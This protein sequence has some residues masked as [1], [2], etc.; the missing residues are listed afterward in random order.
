MDLELCLGTWKKNMPE[1]G[2]GS[3]KEV[4]VLHSSV[5][6]VTSAGYSKLGVPGYQNRFWY[7]EDL[8]N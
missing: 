7:Q 2:T 8:E 1:Y 6:A 5:K 4:G 3:V